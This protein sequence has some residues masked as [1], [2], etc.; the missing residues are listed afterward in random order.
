MWLCVFAMFVVRLRSFHA[1]EQ[2]LRQL[3]G[4]RAW[5]GPGRR[6]SADTLGRA[7]ARLDLPALRAL[8]ATVNRRAWRAKMIHGPVG[9]SYRVVAVDGHE[10]WASRARC[11]AECLTR[12]VTV[13]HRGQVVREYYHRVVVAQ[14]VGVTPPALLDVERIRPGEGEVVAARR[15][16]AR[17]VA[18]SGRL[19]DIVTADAL[20][21]EAPFISQVLAA[22]KHV[23]VVLKQE[24]R[25]LYE[26]AEELRG[27]IA[28][29]VA[30][31]GARTTRLWD[32]PALDAFP[33]L[34]RPVRVVWAEEATVRR[35]RVGGQ[36]QE[37]IEEGRWIWV[38]DLPAAVVPAGTIQRWG[39]ARWD[40][41]NRGFNELA[42]LWHMDHC[43][44]HQVVAV[45]ALLL[46]LALAF[47]LTYLFYTRNLKPAAWRPLTRLA[48]A[49]RLRADFAQWAGASVWPEGTGP[50]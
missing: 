15:L 47:V 7:L 13:G 19:I 37:G 22:G 30:S 34:G 20:Y 11:C 10:L 43:F 46:T 32:L 36:L 9:E 48:L 18:T 49:D 38:T 25:A 21:L 3:P 17:I 42:T 6:P 29:V 33:T 28:P 50:G 24:A 26:V 31:E 12:E 45:E 2:A 16:L 39:H 27:L 1:L 23:V 8:V 5:L 14:W 4:W 41:E 44:V 35:R 40:I